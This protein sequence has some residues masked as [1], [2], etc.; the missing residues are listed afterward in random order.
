VRADLAKARRRASAS[1][2]AAKRLGGI[3]A[4][5]ANGFWTETLL[6]MR[7]QPHGNQA[8]MLERTAMLLDLLADRAGW[9]GR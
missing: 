8:E 9:P 7:N 1:Y 4:L 6:S 2:D 5:R 3:S